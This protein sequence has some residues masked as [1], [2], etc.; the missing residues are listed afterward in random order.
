[1]CLCAARAALIV[2]PFP[3]LARRLG[4]FVSPADTRVAHARA[5]LS[6]GHGRLAEQIAWAVSRAARHVPFRAACLPQAMTAR[7]MLR[8]RG[9]ASVLYFG[10]TKNAA[11]R[12]GPHAWLEAAG[13]EVTGYPVARDATEI[14]CFV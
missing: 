8:R 3:R 5:A 13:V 4:S 11:E 14:A 7:I 10:A 2:V 9:I 6:P 12:F 1:M